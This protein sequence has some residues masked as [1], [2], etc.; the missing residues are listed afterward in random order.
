MANLKERTLVILK[1]DALQ[2]GILGELIHRFE[3]KGLKVVAIK[4]AK[5]S[6]LLLNKHYAHHKDKPFFTGLKKFMRSSPVVLMVLEGLESVRVARQ[7]CGPTDG[8]NA[9]AGTIRGD[10]SISTQANIIHTSENTVVA[11]QE[12]KRF[13]KLSELFE[14]RKCDLEF[15]YGVEERSH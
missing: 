13:F 4:M 2:R 8:K 15:I 1:P 14:Y 9:P 10:F 5:L 3:R 12:I 6:D 11:K 7:I